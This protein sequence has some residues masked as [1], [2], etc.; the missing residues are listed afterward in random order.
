MEQ[1]PPTITYT[2]PTT[3]FVTHPITV[4]A[5]P[6]IFT[7]TG[8]GSYCAGGTGL[9][10]GL[11]GSATGINYQLVLGGS[12]NVG[13]ALPG[14]G[15]SLDFGIQTTGGTYTIAA[16]NPATGCSINMSGSIIIIVNPLPPTFF[17]TGGGSYCSGAA[18]SAVGLFGSSTG[19]RYQL[20]NNGTIAVGSPVS[21]TGSAI[22]F[23]P[24]T[25]AGTYTAVATDSV[26]ACVSNMSGSVTVSINPLPANHNVTGGGAYCTNGTGVHIGLNGSN[27]GVNYQLSNG[28]P[29]GSVVAG[30]GSSLDFGIITTAGTYTIAAT[31]LATLCTSNMLGSALVSVNPLPAVF[32]ISGGG[33][34]CAGATGQLIN[35]SG[36]AVGFNYQLFVGPL[37]VSGVFAG[38]GF[39]INFGAQTTAGTYTAI[40][41]NPITG[42]INTMTGTPGV[43]VNPVPAVFA[44]SGGGNICAGGT[45]VTIN[46]SGSATGVNYT[47]FNSA[48]AAPLGSIA[49]TGSAIAS[50]AETV[51][52]IYIVTA[53][54]STTGC[55]DTMNGNATIIVN[56][57][58]TTYTV[59]GGG[60]YCSGDPGIHIGL[61]NSDVTVKYQLFNSPTPTGVN[62]PIGSPVTG[63]G[64]ALDFGLQTAAGTYKVVG[65][66]ITTLCTNNMANTVTVTVNVL[67][68]A[69]TVT[70]GGSY[71]T[72]SV[73]PHI[74]L[75]NS[76]TSA[77]YQLYN[78]T[79]PVGSP[80]AGLGNPLG[81][82]VFPLDFGAQT[83]GG[84]YTIIATN[85]S[86]TSAGTSCSS[87]M[88]GTATITAIALPALNTVT[89][90]G[91]FCS[92]GTGVHV[93]LNGSVTGNNYQLFVG[94]A[95][96]GITLT[97]T[98]APLDFGAQVIG[99]AYT[100]IATSITASCSNTM[101]GSVTVTV[102]PLPAIFSI[103]GGGSYCTGGAGVHV[104]LSGS[105]AGISYQLQIGSVL[106]GL[107]ITGTGSAL[108]FGLQT[109]AGTYKIIATNT[110]TTCTSNMSGSVVV[111]TSA[112]PSVYTMTGGG[113][114]CA[115][116]TGADIG[117]SGSVTGVTYQAYNGGSPVG[118][119]VAGTGGALNFGFHT[120]A[121]SY[122]AIATDNT[123]N[124]TSNMAASVSVTVN[125]LPTTYTVAGGGSFCP[126]GT[127]ADVTMSGSDAGISYQLFTGGLPVE[128][129]LTGSGST[130]DFGLETTPG[131]YT[132]V[133]T[134]TITGCINNM[135]GSATISLYPLPNVYTV[136]G[137]G[138]YCAGLTG[139]DVSL[140]GSDNGVNYQLYNGSLPMGSPMAGTGFA[141]DFGLETAA[142]IYTVVATNAITGCTINM[143][144]SPSI[145]INPLPVVYML[146]AAAVIAPAAAALMWR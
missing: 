61:S 43:T 103:T 15:S 68:T 27:T 52:A 16:I 90:G 80:I 76:I 77:K 31:N 49:G 56:P 141:I 5:L 58:P 6:A 146:P 4:N 85:T 26:H 74:G 91:S 84:I 120:G 113:S 60:T 100:V 38:T 12:T 82:P 70:G 28:T 75:S 99:G 96:T 83:A 114:Y 18:G 47:L 92:G 9:H 105:T 102:N 62:T 122:T 125:P 88:T 41:T 94:A 135:T 40:A 87:T 131:I 89:G 121:G 10:I 51:G 136:L 106:V 118:S 86:V 109:V 8:G 36:S 112:P 44:V 55:S 35:S 11:S 124:C 19:V 73:G 3:C 142:G 59:T 53:S 140:S 144:G 37:P 98:G 54:N 21:G 95:T 32:A 39:P 79:S 110:V 65:T 119:P 34:I 24:Q 48:G 132:A 134:N 126:G 108:D 104:G 45:G 33:T 29:V 107:P 115:G 66:N 71:C 123:T 64:A 17:V 129:A 30:T 130:L 78:G 1:V 117:L 63:T 46:L 143:T 81:G 145:A 67:P 128:S 20:F 42:C 111:S 69:F 14:T 25:L 57:L 139:V 97:G 127:G 72:G 137:G 13:T 101:T 7:A 93:G 23:G 133:A 50:P 22:S 116:G 138:S 2:L